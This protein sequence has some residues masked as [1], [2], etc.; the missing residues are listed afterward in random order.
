[1]KKRPEKAYKNLEFL[2]SGDARLVRML[3]EYL[4]P[5]NRLRRND[6]VDTIVFFGSAR[7]RSSAD[8]RKELAAARRK[9]SRGR[10]A[11]K[12]AAL[13]RELQMAR[14]Y[15]EAVELARLLTVWS[16][17]I[18]RDGRRF[19]ICSGGGGG[20]ME[21]ANRGAKRAGGLSVGFNISLPHEQHPNR[22]ITPALNFE[23]HYFFMRK[24]WFMYL[25]KALVIFPGGFGTLD[26]LFEVL[27]LI[28][29]KKTK[30]KMPVVIYGTEYWNEVL[31]FQAMVR[32]G[33]LSEDELDTIHF[34]D[35][36]EEACEYLSETLSEYYLLP[37]PAQ[38]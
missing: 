4:E 16:N 10:H 18:G 31:D 24:F 23:F 27:T 21:A 13:E 3:A 5:R 32:R 22:F 19:I 9:K 36:P 30:K 2:N 17:G 11:Q 38:D 6:V 28:Q 26:E 7:L 37:D 34:S 29:T 33:T 12:L 8:V 20:I 1:M 14:Y 15:D 35:E 25:A